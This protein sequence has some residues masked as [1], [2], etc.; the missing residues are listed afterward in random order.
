MASNTYKTQLYREN[1]LFSMLEIM[2][3]NWH[4]FP[5][6]MDMGICAAIWG[7]VIYRNKQKYKSQCT[8]QPMP[9][10]IKK[11]IKSL[12]LLHKELITFLLVAA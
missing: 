10:F 5:Y 3:G 1:T 7:K 6:V 12:K 2:Q 4:D 11:K 8:M 9:R